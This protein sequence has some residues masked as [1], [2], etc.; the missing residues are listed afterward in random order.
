MHEQDGEKPPCDKCLPD[1]WQ[2]N[3]PIYAV[4]SRVC[5]QHIMAEYQPIDLNLM[6]VFKVMDVVGIRKEDQLFCLDLV[7]KA[8]HKVLKI[9]RQKK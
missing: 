6:P 1:L 9:K 5:G 4:Y 7:Q 8:Y 3:Q 2:E